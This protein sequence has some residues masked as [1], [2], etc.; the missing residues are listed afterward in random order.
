M[1]GN[2]LRAVDGF[3][4][5]LGNSVTIRVRATD[6]GG[7]FLE[8]ILLF[9]VVEVSNDVV[10]N[11]IHFNP[12]DNTVRQEFVELYNPAGSDADLTGW[13]LSGA[14]SYSFPA[15]SVI[16][17]DGYLVIAEDPVTLGTTLG[18]S[19]LGPYGGQLDSEGED[20]PAAGS[21]TT[22]WLILPTTGWDFPGRCWADG[23]RGLD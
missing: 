19:A 16:P 11:E 21:E 5:Q 13:R 2:Q 8:K 23:P 22:W 12:P 10:I 9:T 6:P 14:V 17:A 15:G 1:V 7:L 18:A 3:A 4:G 20:H